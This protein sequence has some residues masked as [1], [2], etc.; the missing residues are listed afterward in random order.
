VDLV[1]SRIDKL[2]QIRDIQDEIDSNQAQRYSFD[3]G[4]AVII[5]LGIVVCGVVTGGTC[6]VPFAVGGLA[7]VA[8]AV[9]K[10][11]AAASLLP[12]LEELQGELTQIDTNL[13]GRF[14]AANP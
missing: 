2:D 11:A 12:T 6:F 9:S 14:G 3:A 10:N 13:R 5:G 4:A 1:E 7:A 8:Q